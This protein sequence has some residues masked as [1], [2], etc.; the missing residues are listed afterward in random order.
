VTGK[1]RPGAA[2]LLTREELDVLRVLGQVGRFTVPDNLARRL[3]VSRQKVVHL[4]CGLEAAR[5]VKVKRLPKMT[6]YEISPRGRE[7]LHEER[8]D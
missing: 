1:V 7:C 8:G 3:N 6:T 5:L 4:V 2:G